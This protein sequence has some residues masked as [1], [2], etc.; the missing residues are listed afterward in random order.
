M[1]D[2]GLFLFS[3]TADYRPKNENK[4]VYY[5]LA[6]D[7]KMARERF[8]DKISWLKIY[9]CE[10]ITDSVKIDEIMFHP[11]KHIVF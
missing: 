4:P 7:S 6:Y 8:S 11:D 5:V 10:K 3:I 1:E 9:S 2:A